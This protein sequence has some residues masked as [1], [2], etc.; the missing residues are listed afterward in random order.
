MKKLL[1]FILIAACTIMTFGAAAF[2]QEDV[3]T[4]FG[5]TP[6]GIALNGSRIIIMYEDD[7]TEEDIAAINA[8]YGLV[9]AKKLKLIKGQSAVVGKSRLDEMLKEKKIK[10]IESDFK[11][12]ASPKPTKPDKET[13][14]PAAQVIPWNMERINA[15]DGSLAERTHG[16]PS[17]IGVNVA[18]MDTGIDMNHP[19]LNVTGGV[20]IINAVKS[21]DDD[22]GHGTHVAGIVAAQDNSIG[23]VGVAPNVNLYAIKVLDRKGSGYTS[24]VIAGIE[25]AIE[26]DIKIINMSLGSDYK[27][28]SLE[29]AIGSAAGAGIIVIAAA[30]NDS[31]AVDYP[32]AF[33]NTI[34]VSATDQAD[35]LANFSSRGPQVDVAAP[36]VS[37]YSTYKNGEYRTFNGTSMATPHV[38]GVIALM[39]ENEPALD[40][41]GIKAD[42]LQAACTDIGK[43]GKDEN[44]G[45]GLIDA[46]KAGGIN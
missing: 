33:D 16:L 29:V 10:K 34:A 12:H 11:V 46:A 37:I 23:T 17:G 28:D 41:N 24:N 7:A 2:S 35:E 30:G 18:V 45:Y 8:K 4:G 9:N 6:P 5:A 14:Q 44:F 43:A 21:P 1:S 39:V 19:D 22:N 42:K 36:G 3:K 26:N 15:Y 13:S 31:S 20:N 25:W 27:S 40:I 38:A 32:A